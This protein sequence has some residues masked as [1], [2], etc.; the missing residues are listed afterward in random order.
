MNA[1]RRFARLIGYDGGM[2]FSVRDVFAF[3]F[4]IAVVVWVFRL[5]AFG[6]TFGF[7]LLGPVTLISFLGIIAILSKA[8]ERKM[9]DDERSQ[10][11]QN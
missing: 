3:T 2:R 4:L 5:V 11:S 1:S 8:Q 10:N 9:R 7:L 6:G